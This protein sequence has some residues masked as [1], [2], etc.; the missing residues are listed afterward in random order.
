MVRKLVITGILH[1]PLYIYSGHQ[2][3]YEMWHGGGSP[4]YEGYSKPR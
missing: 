1:K 2:L 3:I 4:Y